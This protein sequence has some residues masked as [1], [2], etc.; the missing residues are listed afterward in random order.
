MSLL[1]K[2]PAKEVFWGAGNNP[3][4]PDCYCD[5]RGPGKS[6]PEGHEERLKAIETQQELAKGDCDKVLRDTVIIDLD[7]NI[8]PPSKEAKKIREWETSTMLFEVYEEPN[9]IVRVMETKK[10]ETTSS[11][12]NPNERGLL[13][14]KD[15]PKEEPKQIKQEECCCDSDKCNNT[16]LQQILDKLEAIEA[17]LKK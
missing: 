2:D 15:T 10:E 11:K 5:A 14:K 16:T 7:G 12:Q 3:N 1:K 17:L 6:W 13:R 4:N 9:G 8:V